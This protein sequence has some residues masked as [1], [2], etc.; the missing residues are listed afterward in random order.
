MMARSLSKQITATTADVR[1]YRE[2]VDRAFVNHWHALCTDL[3]RYLLQA[4][5]ILRPLGGKQ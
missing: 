2:M 5:C 1:N 4:L 3:I